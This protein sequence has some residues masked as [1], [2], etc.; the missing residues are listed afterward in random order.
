MR[1][2]IVLFFREEL[3][4]YT[5]IEKKRMKRKNNLF[6]RLLCLLTIALTYTTNVFPLSK[7]M[8]YLDRGVVA[9][10]T[11]NGVFVSWRVLGTEGDE[12][13]FNLYRDGTKINDTPITTKSNFLDKQGS[14]NSQYTVKSVVD[15]SEKSVSEPVG[16]WGQQYKTLTLN[17]PAGGSNPSGNYTYTP[18]DMSVG[19][20]DGDGQYE[21]F[22]KWDPS[23][24][25]DNSNSGYTGNVFIDCY[26]LDGT[27][28]WRIDLGK[29]IRAGAHYTQFQVYDYDGD[30]K[31]EM[32]CKTA[33][34]SKDGKGKSIRMNNDDPNQDYRNSSGYILSG[35]EYLTI[36]SG[37][38]GEEIHTI[39][40]NPGRGNISNKSTW[41]DN[42]GN[43]VDR[44]LACTAYLDGVHPS[45]VMCRGYYTQSNLVAYD[46]KDGKLVQRWEHH[47]TTAGQGAYGEGFHNISVADVDNDGF[48]EI[49]YGSASIDHDGRLQYRK[50]FGHG[51]AM[52]ISQIDPSTP[53]LEGWFVHEEEPSDYSFELRNLRTGDVIFRGSGQ[54]DNGRGLSADI[55]A[56]HRGLECWSSRG[57]GVYDCK[58]K[59]I[60]SKKPSINF[61]TYWDGDLQD[62]LLDGNV[63]TKWNGHE[64]DTLIVLQ[65]SS[66]NGSKANP[67]LS[68]D[69]FGDWREEIITYNNNNP[70]QIFIYTTTIETQHRLFTPMHDPIYRCGIAWQNTAYNQPPHLGF[71]I[72]DGVS[73]VQL[74]DIYYAK[75]PTPPTQAM[76]STSG[77]LE[78]TLFPNEEMESVTFTYGGASTDL[79]VASS[80]DFEGAINRRDNSVIVTGRFTHSGSVTVTTVGGE[81]PITK[82]LII[83]VLPEDTKRIA[84]V[85]DPSNA[86]YGNDKILASLK[87]NQDFF[88]EEIDAYDTENDFGKYE[89]VII[90]EETPSTAPIM[91]QLK[92]LDKPILNLKV[93]G[94][95]N[96]E[97]AWNWATTG[98]GDNYEAT[99]LTVAQEHLSHPMFKDVEFTN[100]NEVR[101]V[102]NV[103][104]KALTYMN[105]ESFS[106]AQG[107]INAIASVKDAAQVS[108]LEIRPGSSVGGTDIT[109]KYIQ[110]GLNSSSYGNLTDDALRIISNACYYLMDM[111]REETGTTNIQKGY[112]TNLYPNPTEGE[113]HLI[114]YAEQSHTTTLT[115]SNLLGNRLRKEEVR[116]EI[117][118]NDIE[119]D[120]GTL[121]I[122]NY[123]IQVDGQIFRMIKQ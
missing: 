82:E 119:I 95:K 107:T 17:R 115:I 101:M 51:D 64:A 74:P 94:Y 28:L 93:H 106:N 113:T 31:A 44:F 2:T 85:T 120:C 37:E 8:E 6:R 46:F 42:Y 114:L 15:G 32:V 80:L 122:G 45:V 81:N 49:I 117:G 67:C 18:N 16:V 4:V 29:N 43:R 13:S 108:I 110:I 23:N 9:V 71:Y 118:I 109:Q 1:Q 105:P 111:N 103:N 62:E 36:F 100:G 116:L 61:R 11:N 52:H 89:L 12:V 60:S 30:G 35:P 76:M 112:H 54:K 25:Q 10:K 98:Y 72:G 121:E 34:G 75:E 63:I 57:D 20:A 97:G 87:G 24:A 84:Y 41:G 40:Y 53:D 33:P 47:S 65:G 83:N 66:I 48:D 70:S 123:T 38:T 3:E 5:T 58:G 91:A 77:K 102:T 69:L 59:V 27:F 99:T 90:S 78:Q 50:G 39:A 56:S 68:A 55:D 22:V 88:I 19:D 14:Q 73:D 26:K 104:N 96:A 79:E 7:Q 86:N 21:L 92:G